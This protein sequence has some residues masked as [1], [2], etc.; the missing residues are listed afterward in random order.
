[1]TCQLCDR[2]DSAEIYNDGAHSLELC[3]VH[4]EWIMRALVKMWL[5]LENE[6]QRARN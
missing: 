4:Q 3:P 1:M 2:T 5:G 6:F